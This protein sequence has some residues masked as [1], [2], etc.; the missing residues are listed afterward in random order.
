[1]T[2]LTI[3]IRGDNAD[4]KGAIAIAIAEMR[5]VDKQA[6]DTAKVQAA[7]V[8][9]TRDLIA[10]I[11]KDQAAKQVAEAKKAADE[12]A[13]QSKRTADEAMRESRR[14]ADAQRRDFEAVAKASQAARNQEVRAHQVAAKEAMKASQSSVQGFSLMG[15]AAGQ[16]RD[17]LTGVAGQFALL[18]VGQQIIGEIEKSFQ[19]AADN[20][21][22]ASKFVQEYRKDL[23]ELAALKGRM[24][25]TTTET[26]E[27]LAFRSQTL[28]SKEQAK[29]LQ[30]G[31]LNVGQSEITTA[32]NKG[33]ISQGESNK[34]AVWVGKMQAAESGDAR[35]YGELAG[36]LPSVMPVKPG[37]Q[38]GAEAVQKQFAQIYKLIQF[39]SSDWD[40]GIKQLT[41]NLNL[42]K[43][44]VFQ[45][46]G[47]QAMVQSLY[48]K[49]TPAEAGDKT[50]RLARATIGSQGR[51]KGVKTDAEDA[52]KVG[53]YLKSIQ[54]GDV[55]NARQV[56]EKVA[57]DLEAQETAYG[58]R[59][60]SWSP[61][62]Y[63]V[64]KGYGNQEDREALMEYA[65]LRKGGTVASF[66]AVRDQPLSTDAIDKDIATYQA[67]DPDALRK[68]AEL[69]EENAKV[70]LGAG[71]LGYLK[72]A[73]MTALARLRSRGDTNYSYEEY[74]A[75][76]R[77][78]PFNLGIASQVQNEMMAMFYPEQAK[79]NA[80]PHGVENT[81]GM[82]AFDSD[83]QM[84]AKLWEVG[85]RIAGGG[86]DV[87]PGA[88]A[89]GVLAQEQLAETKK[90]REL[91]EAA[92]K[93]AAPPMPLGARAVP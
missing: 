25:D 14:A 68:Q 75:R 5:K 46:V 28:Q 92:N 41:A 33:K 47:E 76:G 61:Y 21:N 26:A 63:L 24:G 90:M 86:G 1:M 23:L 19:R 93:A 35:A 67:V 87:L 49:S 32:T 50:R 53:E 2:P 13:R 9:Q 88:G 37:E 10:S 39:G 48:S 85:K 17:V 81:L 43:M 69:A 22:E 11:A 80:F 84:A 73:E 20:A 12:Q 7:A 77:T 64:G 66:Q 51:M 58:K 82:T 79:T 74:H 62:R 45:D 4:L 70:A 60:E 71:P 6:A 18:N 78:N 83:K 44:G 29:Q 36:A 89:P 57:D 65:A 40:Q 59:G 54:V 42:T 8:K 55:N 27:N 16:F 3:K 38:L 56:V 72:D 52:M 91:L 15:A 34:V 30:Q 31:M